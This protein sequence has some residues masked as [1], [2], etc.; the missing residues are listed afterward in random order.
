LHALQAAGS[1]HAARDA[2]LC[3]REAAADA[4]EAALQERSGELQARQAELEELQASLS[5]DAAKLNEQLN[6]FE[7][8]R[9]AAVKELQVGYACALVLHAW[10]LEALQ[11]LCIAP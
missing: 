9:E 10:W 1:Q 11:S 3:G 8:R 6:T 2:A 5:A 4:A 7:A